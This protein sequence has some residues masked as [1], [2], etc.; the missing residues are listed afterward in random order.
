MDLSEKAGPSDAPG[1][2]GNGRNHFLSLG[3]PVERRT[4]PARRPNESRLLRGY[5]SGTVRR[6]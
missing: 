3:T 6:E 4:A 1:A 2:K 5:R